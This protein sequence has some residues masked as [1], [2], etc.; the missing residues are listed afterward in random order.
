MVLLTFMISLFL[1]SGGFATNFIQWQTYSNQ[2]FDQAKKNHQLIL[3]YGMSERCHWCKKMEATTWSSSQIISAVQESFIPT[4]IDADTNIDI[5]DLYKINSLPATVI[6]NS[7]KK[8]VKIFTGYF[9]PEQMIEMLN[10]ITLEN[11]KI[12]TAPYADIS[13][14]NQQT[15]ANK[16]GFMISELIHYYMVS[17]DVF[18]LNL[19]IKTAR[20]VDNN[21]K[22]LNGGFRHEKNNNS[23]LYLNDTVSMGMA[24]IDLHKATTNREY[25]NSALECAKFINSTFL[26]TT[27]K[28]GFVSSNH[29]LKNI[30]IE[31]V[32]LIKFI[33][34]LYGYTG[35]KFLQKMQLSAYHYLTKPE[36]ITSIS[37]SQALMIQDRVNN[38]PTHIVIVG[39]KSDLNA[40]KLYTT[41][42]MYSLDYTRLE[43]WDKTQGPLLNS[44]IQYPDLGK[45]AAYTCQGFQC[46]L[47]LY[48]SQDLTN[49]FHTN[50]VTPM[51][52]KPT[53][54]AEK[55]SLTDRLLMGKNWFL[56]IIGFMGCGL[57]LSFTPCVLPLVPIIASIIVGQTIGV[58]KEKT[59]LLCLTYVL[60]MSFTYAVIGLLA[61]AF[62][63]YIQVYTQGIWVISLFSLIFLTLALSMLGA[64]ELRIPNF[65]LQ[66]MNEKSALQ[67]GG[68]FLGVMGMGVLGTLI[69]SPCVT[70]PLAGV[71]SFIAKTSNYTLGAVGLFS[72][73][74]GMGLPL[75]IISLFSKNILPRASRWN[76][77]VKVFF[78]LILLG[79]SIWIIS[80]VI[81]HVITT[82]LWSAYFFLTS[83]Y[84]GITK[85]KTKLLFD[86]FWKMMT[87]MVFTFAAALL[88]YALYFNSDL[89]SLSNSTNSSFSA[90]LF[91]DIKSKADLKLAISNA[92]RNNLPVLVD[93]SAKWC[94]AC[95]SMEK[96]VFNDSKVMS[97]LNKFTLLRIDLTN[98]TADSMALA[99]EFNVVGP[100]VVLF[101]NNHGELAN[102]RVTGDLS[103][104]QF[105]NI[106]HQILNNRAEKSI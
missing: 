12:L 7:D 90:P 35:D 27:E 32:E 18:S 36:V 77:K 60:S 80:R 28:V 48:T 46:S 54:V 97:L 106:L 99:H 104:D 22:I 17:G 100:P 26:N 102:L 76:D 25:L 82:F 37:P 30:P 29:S 4:R 34:L 13:S 53:S 87:F 73:S 58:K 41:A 81:S 40:K 5:A 57:L 52:V 94:T 65:I 33:S 23:T 39:S 24:Y 84:M 38:L 96:N 49:A 69:I 83:I 92:N 3:L 2:I 86:K 72:M 71:L 103:S 66:K 67:Q 70:A 89:R 68:S 98:A 56:I 21:L 64:F 47:P 6:L 63:L 85:K 78:G 75:L 105:I 20:W 11:T 44:E 101:F 1:S 10:I 93:F 61:G 91:S 51:H 50:I 43:W 42:L 55:L 31:N 45:S 9:P 16:D 88:F 15:D 79:V 19:A 59:F 14:V 95:M 62:G 74:F 8:V